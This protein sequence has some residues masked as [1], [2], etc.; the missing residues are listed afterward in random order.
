MPTETISI[1]GS[2]LIGSSESQEGSSTIRAFSV[3]SQSE[4]PEAFFEA[5]PEECDRACRLAESSLAE[6]ARMSPETRA[7]FLEA[8][9]DEIMNLGDQLIQRAH[10]E[11]SLP[12]AR[13]EGER[14]R[15][16]GQLRMFAA[17][18]REGRWRDIRIETALPDRA[19]LPR[20]DLRNQKVAIGPVAVF[21]SSNFPLAFSVAG[22]D[23]ASAWAAG[24][25]VVVKAHP[26][27]PGTSE[28]VGRAIQRAI[29]KTGVPEGI[30][31]MIHG[32]N[33]I[34]IQLVQHPAIQAVGFTGSRQG[35]DALVR[36]ANAR[37]VP[38]PVFAEMGSVNPI[39]FFPE[40][41]RQYPELDAQYAASLTLGA[42]QFC[43]NPGLLFVVADEA[44]RELVD[45]LKAII[46]QA[47]SQP[48][49][50]EGIAA[51]YR[52]GCGALAQHRLALAPDSATGHARPHLATVTSG[53]FRSDP[54]LH[55]E[56]F[57]PAGIIVMCQDTAEF[58]SLAREL[59][60]QLTATLWTT[61]VEQ[62]RAQDLLLA[63]TAKAGRV[64]VNGFPTGVEV[65]E[66]MQHG[67]PYPAT[68]DPRFTSVGTGAIARW[69]RPVCYQS[70]PDS[71]LPA[72]LQDANPLG[73]VRRVNGVDTKDSVV[74]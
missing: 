26:A 31:S 45:R 69:A 67:G 58:A 61:E 25:P 24:C 9:A 16:T 7:A 13:L 12:I 4:L 53:E 59:E 27:H 70:V 62:S 23:T 18:V 49:L 3:Q 39:F 46:G 41:V 34:G 8:V 19:P 72:E 74:R 33:E 54:R 52:T 66:A 73:L 68:S 29:Q 32:R 63:L 21:G 40:A 64:I 30:F 43:T 11:S 10:Q 22:G 17:V 1:T 55:A 2:Q 71:M 48:M 14:G 47:G 35:G 5:T 15:T 42:G 38:I 20:V 60:G 37:P 51:A 65:G 28:L 36:A 44:G 56:L 57:G 6:L 50:T